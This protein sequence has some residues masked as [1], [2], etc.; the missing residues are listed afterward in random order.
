MD[1]AEWLLTVAEAVNKMELPITETRSVNVEEVRITAAEVINK[2]KL[3]IILTVIGAVNKVELLI[4]EM[5]MVCKVEFLVTKAGVF[6]GDEFLIKVAHVLDED[7]ENIDK[8]SESA[9]V[10]PILFVEGQ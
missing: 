3:L 7:P 8:V 9:I 6:H 5:R 10:V 4:I 1:E 2:I